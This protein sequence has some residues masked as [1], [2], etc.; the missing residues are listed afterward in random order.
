MSINDEIGDLSGG[1]LHLWDSE[2]SEAIAAAFDPGTERSGITLE[3]DLTGLPQE[4]IAAEI[5]RQIFEGKAI[6]FGT[7]TFSIAKITARNIVEK[8]FEKKNEDEKWFIGYFGKGQD[9][10]PTIC[11]LGWLHQALSV[12]VTPADLIEWGI[13]PFTVAQLVWWQAKPGETRLSQQVRALRNGW[14]L[15]YLAA[16]IRD[17]YGNLTRMIDRNKVP[18]WFLEDFAD[19]IADVRELLDF[20]RDQSRS[21]EK[22]HDAIQELSDERKAEW[23]QAFD[24]HELK[25]ISPDN[26][27]RWAMYP[28]QALAKGTLR[29]PLNSIAR[30]WEQLGH[31]PNDW[32]TTLTEE[33]FGRVGDK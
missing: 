20:F 9:V 31:K 28:A 6:E 33:W 14:G 13:E 22:K 8:F 2:R 25:T 15:R 10:V 7:D 11:A 17:N 1:Q 16:A 24:R 19:D 21:D 27:G 29:E 3:R 5:A 26:R 32:G 4:V 18:D 30:Y 12:G 23:A